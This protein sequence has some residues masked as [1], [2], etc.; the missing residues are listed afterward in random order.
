MKRVYNPASFNVK[1]IL[2]LSGHRPSFVRTS[3]KRLKITE[4]KYAAEITHTQNNEPNSPQVVFE[5]HHHVLPHQR[6]EKRVE[7]LRKQRRRDEANASITLSVHSH[8]VS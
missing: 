4:L 6:L 5:L 8:D 3:I 2:N 1:S 7:E